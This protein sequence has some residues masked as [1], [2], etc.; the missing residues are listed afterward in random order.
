M[1]IIIFMLFALSTNLNAMDSRKAQSTL[2][3]KQI[4]FKKKQIK[5]NKV[6]AESIAKLKKM[7]MLKKARLKNEEN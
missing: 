4:E 7:Q 3:E 2:V 1:K 5:K 6:I